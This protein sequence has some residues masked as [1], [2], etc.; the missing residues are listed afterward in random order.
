MTDTNPRSFGA[1]RDLRIID[2]TQLLSGPYATMMLADQ[3]AK[4]IKVEPPEGDMSRSAGPF[5]PDDEVKALGG[6]FQSIGRNKQSVVLDLKTAEG[7]AALIA[8]VRNADALVENFRSGVMERLG[9]SYEV[10]RDV[11]P[12]LVYGAIRGFGD[13]RSGASP[14]TNWPAF[15]VT[16]QAMGGIMAVTGPDTATPTKVGPGIGDIVPGMFLAFGVLAAIHRARV[17]GHGQYVDIAM[18]DA[19]LALS[20][21]LVW[22]HSVLNVVPVPEGNHHPYFCPFGVYPAKDGFVTI[23]AMR[24]N[25]FEI[26][27]KRLDATDLLDDARFA[28]EA[29]R[30]ENR[31]TLIEAISS[32]TRRLLKRELQDR[33]GGE[34]PFGPVMDIAEIVKDRH[35]IAR[36]MIVDVE[37]PGARPIRIAG[38]PIKMSDTP[39]GV[40]SRSPLLGEDTV[41][42]LR[43][44]GL[45]DDEINAAIQA[46][47][48][49]N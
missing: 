2:L 15:D 26:L 10:L 3:G 24:D 27:C 16:A 19:I 7:K 6:Y 44:A 14:Y 4:V 23:A 11:N 9:L 37:Q 30:V 31:T 48:A 41:S 21:R 13:V 20:E 34:I 42:C 33:L 35:Y 12:R 46:S 49:K 29:S 8:L 5:R 28:S 17:A 47:A 1:L 32:R 38:V 43:D 40:R 22:Q 25:F 39:G 18:V 36:N 45:N